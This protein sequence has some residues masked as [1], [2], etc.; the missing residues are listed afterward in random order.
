MAGV[1]EEAIAAV[2]L[3]CEEK[4]SPEHRDQIRVE[5]SVRGATISIFECRP[6]W[7]PEY[8]PDWTRQSVAQLRYEP[9][10]AVW[11]LHWADRNGRW[12]SYDEVEPTTRL[13][14]LLAE[15]DDD[16]TGI[17]WG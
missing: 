3:Y 2:R 7:R 4:V 10:R 11:R 14:E 13:E 5:C 12:H 8:G 1:P 15:I 17:F 9:A 6:P 16:P